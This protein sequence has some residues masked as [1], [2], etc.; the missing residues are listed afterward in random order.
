MS[1]VVLSSRSQ[2]AIPADERVC[3]CLES[4]QELEPIVEDG[5][6]MLVPVLPIR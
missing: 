2:I 3:A 5:A 6:I 4:S 1:A